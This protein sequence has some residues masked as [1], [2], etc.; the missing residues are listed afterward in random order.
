MKGTCSSLVAQRRYILSVSFHFLLSLPWLISDLP[1]PYPILSLDE[2][3][4]WHVFST[5]SLK[6]EF[7][8]VA[9]N[10][11]RELLKKLVYNVAVAI[12]TKPLKFR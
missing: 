6:D 1:S 5:P 3:A 7:R 12:E 8:G 9:P 10:L 11:R 2:T 4:I